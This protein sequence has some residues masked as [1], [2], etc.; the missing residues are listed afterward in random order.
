MQTSD[1]DTIRYV[2]TVYNLVCSSPKYISAVAA[3]MCGDTKRNI[4]RSSCCKDMCL[5]AGPLLAING[6]ISL[7]NGLIKKR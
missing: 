5:Q 1:L 7:K 2:K 6:V 4:P 3:M